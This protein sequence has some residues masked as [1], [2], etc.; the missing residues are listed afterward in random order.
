MISN[1]RRYTLLRR[2]ALVCALLVLL[3]TSL[4][5][6]MRLS[7]A[8][9]G[10]ADWP[11]CYGQTT[12][13]SDAEAAAITP[14]MAAARLLHRAAA[15]LI[16]LLAVGMLMLCFDTRAALYREGVL[17]LA[18]LL[19]ALALAVLGRFSSGT[20]L[21]AVAIGNLLGGML[22]FAAC[23]RLAVAGRFAHWPR[24]RGWALGAA[25]L[26]LAQVTLGG[27]VSSSFAGLRCETAGG[28]GL[29]D[30]WQAASWRDLDPWREAQPAAA[31]GTAAAGRLAQSL[32]RHVAALLAGALLLLGVAAWRAGRRRSALLLM[33]LLAAQVLA[34]TLLVMLG[35]PLALAVAHNLLAALLLAGVVLLA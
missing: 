32:H 30:A 22:M 2:L 11:A 15:V 16:L 19:L 20:R 14:G 35:L 18:V 29:I 1:E 7:K 31:T 8:G 26:V 9:L 25:L 27:L 6:Y 17:A 33:L 28:C 3:V 34:G 23:A 24:L 4:S 5:A 21:P 10:C 12:T 13:R